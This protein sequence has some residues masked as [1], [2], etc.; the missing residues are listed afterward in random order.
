MIDI[1]IHYSGIV[2]QIR[3][4]LLIRFNTLRCRKPR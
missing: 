1:G 2:E 3:G 4:I